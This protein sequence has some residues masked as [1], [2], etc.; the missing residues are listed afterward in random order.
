M[1]FLA[2][3]MLLGALA[4]AVPIAIHF[5]FRSRYRTVPWA[6]MQFLLTSL[7]QTSRR[8]KFQELL[9]L[10]ARIAVLVLLA[11]A[12]ARPASWTA[13]AGAATGDSVDAVFL[14]D[15]SG[16]MAVHEADG[17]TR[18]D[19]ART[20][21]RAVLDNL[22][23]GSTVQVVAVSDRAVELPEKGLRTPSDFG[24]VR[25]VLDRIEGTHQSTDFRPAFELAGQLLED[26]LNPNRAI[27]LFSDMQ[28]AGFQRQDKDLAETV[29]TLSSQAAIYLVRCGSGSP[30]NV[31]V[32][33]VTPAGSGL[34][35]T[36][37][38]NSVRGPAPQQ[39]QAGRAR[40]DRSANRERRNRGGRSAVVLNKDNQQA[41]GP[42]E[43][44]AVTATARLTKPGLNIVTATI[45]GD[46]LNIDNR[47]DRVVQVHDKVR[48]LVVDGR[49]D[50]REPDKA[51]SF[52]LGHALLTPPESLWGSYHIQPRVV[53]AE[54][55]HP[56]HLD[57]IDLCILA[58]VPVREGVGASDTGLSPEFVSRLA[59]RVKEGQ[60]L[61]I[62]AGD[63]VTADG[64]NRVLLEQHKLLPA[65][66]TKPFDAI[67]KDDPFLIDPSTASAFLSRFQEKPLVLIGLSKVER[68]LG[69]TEP[70]G[71]ETIR[72]LLRYTPV[73]G[74]KTGRPAVVTRKVGD[75][76]VMLVTTSPDTSWTTWP[77]DPP[78][79]FLAFVRESLQGLLPGRAE[80]LNRSVGESLIWHPS[81]ADVGKA[82]SLLTPHGD[83]VRLPAVQ[84]VQGQAAATVPETRLAGIYRIALGINPADEKA[85]V[86]PSPS[87]WSRNQTTP[88]ACASATAWRGCRRGRSPGCSARR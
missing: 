69:V 10:L 55:A 25:T 83:T 48:V 42:G 86:R 44:R 28:A 84:V 47:L 57:G 24:Q 18:L 54:D 23:G 80:G 73:M 79:I 11:I 26:T 65:R 7:E 70:E 45:S 38:L 61:M 3:L 32:V 16:S 30:A 27:Y 77:V 87:A 85:A 72:V 20:A 43:T 68:A 46:D 66:L 78:G 13:L 33:G 29:K 40:R 17:Q 14:V 37:D 49:P 19:H 35:H 64:Y 4:A 60:P 50:K 75:A 5:F 31:S 58:N 6:A 74:E 1:V 82:V 76:T 21:A 88:P 56:R 12:L 53:A 81:P 34:L 39:R 51:A 63:R 8:L 59:E 71:D 41:L 36:G 9:L 62:F 15:T 22:P 52:F 2:P 67:S